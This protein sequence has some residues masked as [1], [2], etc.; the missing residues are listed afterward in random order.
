MMPR[1]TRGL[2]N[3]KILLEIINKDT[4]KDEETDEDRPSH[5][6]ICNSLQVVMKSLES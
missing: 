3:N 1:W 5:L 6:E 2:I 4:I